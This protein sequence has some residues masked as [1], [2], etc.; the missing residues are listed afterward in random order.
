MSEYEDIAA[1]IVSAQRGIVGDVAYSLGRR[2]T[3][4][5]I[6][7]DGRI[8]I[9]GNGPQ[10]VTALVNEYSA[11]TGPLGVR[12]CFNAAQPV[13]DRHGVRDIPAFASLQK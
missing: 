3:G 5:E 9:V 1:A 8:S 11:I 10:V 13:M 12:M 7:D 6:A 2:V 4:L